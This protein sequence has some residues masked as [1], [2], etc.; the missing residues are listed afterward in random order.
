MRKM[1]PLVFMLFTGLILLGCGNR[2][3]E[4]GTADN[5]KESALFVAIGSGDVNKVINELEA[6]PSLLNQPEGRLMQTPLHKAVRS[7]QP[8]IVRILIEAGA[9]FNARDAFAR[10]PLAAALDDDAGEEIIQ[11][12]EDVGA[13]D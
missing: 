8:E 13:E 5:E 3:V 10:S 12:L 1:L 11:I 9:D 4:L 7:R 6:N 2:E